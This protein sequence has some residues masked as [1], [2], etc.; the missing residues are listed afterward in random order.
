MNETLI[1]I[2]T[3]ISKALPA[4]SRNRLYNVA[5]RVN[6]DFDGEMKTY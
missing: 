4:F 1:D 5:A 2:A 3:N 6:G